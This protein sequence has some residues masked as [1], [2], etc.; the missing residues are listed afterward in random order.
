MNDGRGE[1]SFRDYAGITLRG[2]CMGAADVVPGVSGGTMALITGIYEELIQSIRSFDGQALRLLTKRD[3]QGLLNH[4]RWPFLVALLVGI[5]GTIASLSKGITW[6]LVNEPV[7]LWAFFFGLVLASVYTVGARIPTWGMGKIVIALLAAGGAYVLVGLVP[8]ETPQSPLYVFLSAIIAICAMILPGI[9][10]SFILVLLGQYHHILQA[11]ND[12]DI[13]TIAIFGCGAAVGLM[14]FAR[15]LGWV[16]KKY[17]DL[18]LALLTGLML[19]SLRKIWPWKE[20]LSTIEG[21]HGKLIPVEQ[22]NILPQVMT[23]EVI[24]AIVLALMGIVLVLGLER[25]AD[26]DKSI[27]A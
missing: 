23:G 25:L 21:R 14:S 10:G 17:H 15:V 5:L 2:V 24:G 18:T 19:G 12:R 16:F 11:V 20:T 7:L 13:L 3:W 9:S 22:I 26:T 4:I 1:R 6:L 8:V 27:Q